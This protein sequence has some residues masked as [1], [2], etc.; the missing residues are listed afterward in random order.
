MKTIHRLF[1][2]ILAINLNFILIF[3][4][5]SLLQ[6]CKGKKELDPL[7][8]ST[9]IEVAQV[10]AEFCDQKFQDIKTQ[11]LYINLIDTSASAQKTDPTYIMRFH[12]IIQDSQADHGRAEDLYTLINFNDDAQVLIPWTPRGTENTPYYNNLVYNTYNNPSSW[13]GDQGFSDMTKGV[14]LAKSL[15]IKYIED[16][17]IFSGNNTVL[18]ITLMVAS[19]GRPTSQ[20]QGELTEAQV[21]DA[22]VG[23][24]QNP[25]NGLMGLL[26]NSNYSR[27]INKINVVSTY[28]WGN[29]LGGQYGATADPTHEALM[30]EIALRTGGRFLMFNYGRP[31]NYNLFGDAAKKIK[32]ELLS[33]HLHF[34]SFVW[35]PKSKEPKYDSDGD[36]IM[37]EK[38]REL[39]SNPEVIDTDGDGLNDGVEYK[40]TGKP[41]RENDCSKSEIFPLCISFADE[42]NVISDLDGDGLNNCEENLLAT[43]YSVADTNFNGIT[44]YEEY[45]MGINPALPNSWTMDSDGDKKRNFDE[46]LQFLPSNINNNQLADV[47]IKPVTYF[48]EKTLELNDGR[49]CYR[50]VINNV[51]S[52]F[53]ATPTDLY[54]VYQDFSSTKTNYFSRASFNVSA[55]QSTKIINEDFKQIDLDTIP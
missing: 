9:S 43:S 22:F 5:F 17:V 31:V 53:N 15:I 30:R 14:L 41:C 11:K 23:N 6:S 36:G 8:I 18:E 42:N 51:P 39:G 35:D 3:I 16:N 40:L 7:Q 38:E 48:M 19:D 27:Y 34:K 37:D 33:A 54:L 24:A 45:Q 21:L 50:L 44:D 26:K 12:P 20:T 47:G 55:N 1:P 2:M 13:G 46:I 49:S 4:N 28:F 32:K 10:E 29:M 25:N 52:R